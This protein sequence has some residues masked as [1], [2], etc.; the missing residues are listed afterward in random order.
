MQ[1]AGAPGN[2]TYVAAEHR[3]CTGLVPGR[4]RTTQ[5][6]AQAGD[7]SAASLHRRPSRARSATSTWI[8]L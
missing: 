4:H 1:A 7:Q 5:R 3:E 8:G 6:T 2:R